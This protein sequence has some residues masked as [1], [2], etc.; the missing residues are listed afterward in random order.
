MVSLEKC[1]ES[2][3]CGQATSIQ[4]HECSETVHIKSLYEISAF[5]N[6]TTYPLIFNKTEVR[7]DQ[8]VRQLPS[9]FHV[10]QA[11]SVFE[12]IY[13]ITFFYYFL[14]ERSLY[15]F[16]MTTQ[17]NKCIATIVNASTC[18]RNSFKP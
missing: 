5:L 8:I 12:M 9:Y 2:M 15:I 6:K 13:L 11:I 14:I 17:K 7:V 1:S 10:T 4:S 16:K 18:K 3:N